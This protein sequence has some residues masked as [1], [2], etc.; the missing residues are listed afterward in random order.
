MNQN[1]IQHIALQSFQAGFDAA[2]DGFRDEVIAGLTRV[3]IKIFA[4]LGG[5]DPVARLL[6]QQLA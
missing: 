1:D 6:R 2:G 4:G 5:D 3:G